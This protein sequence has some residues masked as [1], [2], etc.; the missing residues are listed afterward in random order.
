MIEKH[1]IFFPERELLE[2]PAQW[3]LSFEEAY[4]P[5]SDGVALHG[6]FAPG[7]S[8][9][10]W[11]WLHGNGGNIG[12]R[13]EHL[14]LLHSRLDVNIL[15]F[16]YRGYGRSEGRASEK[17]TYR[18]AR[19]A[20]DYVRSRP[21]ISPRKIIY[22][23]HS[24]GAAV[25]VWLATQ[26]RPYGLI[27]ESPF[28]SVKDMAKLFYPYLPLYLLVRGKYDSISRIGKVSCPLLIVHGDEDEVVPISQGR[29][30]YDA[31]R[32]PKSFH[33]ITGAGHSDGYIVGGEAYF[34]ALEEFMTSLGE[35]V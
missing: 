27:L 35:R 3:G 9:V 31:A 6:W 22:S 25:A 10:T 13:L 29:Q 21:D 24:L 15:L 20:L 33:A 30:L 18:D 17:G 14:A 1:F 7:G 19:G 2:T 34:Q 11:I 28:T 32:E 16:D 12:H 5:A 8:D 4:F 26:H 23:G